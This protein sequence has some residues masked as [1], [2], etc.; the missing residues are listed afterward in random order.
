MRLGL[1]LSEAANGLRRNAS[2]VVSVV[3]VT[4]ISLTFVGVAV[5]MQMQI[6]QMK[7]F[8]YDRAQVGIYMC[9]AISPGETCTAGEAT[10]EQ[11]DTVTAQLESPTLAPFI[12]KYYFETHDQAFENFKKQFSGNPVADYVTPDQL[13]QTFWVNL[14]DPSQSDVLVESLSG[15]SGVENVADQRKYLDQIFAV[16]NVASYTAIGIA[17][18]MLVAAALLIATTI[19]LSAFSRRRELGIMRLVGASNRFI[20][21]P[22]ILE[23][24]FAALLGSLLAGGAVMAI[25]LWFV[26]G[27]LGDRLTSF[28][29][30][31]VDDALVVVPILLL[32]GAVLAAFSANFA[33]TRYL[34][35]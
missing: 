3:L 8:W 12:D 27:Y 9:T 11:I 34:K 1:V 30:V 17:S 31:G 26:Q 28:S 18:L 5:L 25:V 35:V 24:V 6:G 21:T 19:R 10:Q 14:K 13:N 7:N 15:V 22:F 33:I 20:Q 23:G 2:M 29:L 32:V 16:L 4:F